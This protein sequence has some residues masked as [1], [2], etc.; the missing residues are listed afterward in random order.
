LNIEENRNDE[1]IDRS[2]H[3]CSGVEFAAG[4]RRC[5]RR[6]AVYDKSCKSCHGPEGAG[7]PAV[8]KM[9][10][11]E[12]KALGSKEVQAK[13]DDDLKAVITK[14]TGKMKPIMSLSG[15]QVSAVVAFVRTL[16]E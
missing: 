6:K 3:G 15:D 10:K 12:M 11:V 9:M 14:G 1:K 2:F 16:K 8:A 13:S 7:N 5:R 4:R